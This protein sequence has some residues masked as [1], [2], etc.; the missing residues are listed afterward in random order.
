MRLQKCFNEQPGD[1]WFFVSDGEINI[2]LFNED[3][4]RAM[5][6]WGGVDPN[7][8]IASVKAGNIDGG[9]W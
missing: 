1:V 6:G 4:E 2:M 5:D 7:F 8:R 3:G 9:S